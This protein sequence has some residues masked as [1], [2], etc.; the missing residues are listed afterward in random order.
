[1]PR[2]IGAWQAE[3]LLHVILRES[4]SLAAQLLRANGIE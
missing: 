3:G 1:M 4:D 2:R